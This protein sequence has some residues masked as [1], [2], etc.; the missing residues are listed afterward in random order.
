VCLLGHVSPALNCFVV[1]VA[2]SFGL[3]DLLKLAMNHSLFEFSE[4]ISPIPITGF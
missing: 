3:D 4:G 2:L 1:A